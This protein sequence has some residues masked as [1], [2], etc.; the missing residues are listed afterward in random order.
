M[1]SITLDLSIEEIN[2]IL[3]LLGNQPYVQ[4]FGLIEKIKQQAAGQMQPVHEMVE[5]KMQMEKADA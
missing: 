3:A 2:A 4:V 1:D 5:S